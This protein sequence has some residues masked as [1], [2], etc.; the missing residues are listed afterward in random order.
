MGEAKAYLDSNM[1]LALLKEE[2]D[3]R[4]ALVPDS[5]KRLSK[6]GVEVV[7]SSGAGLLAG[8]S[9]SEYEAAGA[10]VVDPNDL[11]QDA[12]VVVGINRVVDMDSRLRGDGRENG[13]PV[14]ISMMDPL[15]DPG[16]LERL[17]SAGIK[18]FALEKIPR[19]SRA[20][21][22]DVLSSQANLAGYKA[23]I[24][25]ADR[26]SKILPMLMT[27]AG[28]ISPAKVLVLGAGV[29]GLQAIATARRLGA[30]V[31]GYDV[32]EVVKEQIE[33]LG[34]KF[35]TLKLEESGEGAGGY[36]KALGEDS[37]RMQQDALGDVAKD[38]DIIISTA[39]I[40]GRPAPRLL[41]SDAIQK[42]KPGSVI[43]DMAAC[44]GGNIE[45]SKVDEEINLHGVKILGPSNLPSQLP[46]DASNVFS[47]NIE[48]FVGL[49][50]KDGEVHI[51][52]G[53]EILKESFVGT[54]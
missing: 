29:A 2:N 30:I 28:T 17:N 9:D 37:Q 15:G 50:L 52:W 16:Y 10:K 23:V 49:M 25:A 24:L 54:R 20:Q 22:M 1:K 35:V 27:A 48:A 40:P 38:M 39:Q 42:M 8:F 36:A 32:R 26:L 31:F 43:V 6:R 19:I 46:L 34:A 5:V 18:G 47:K 44:S 12:E 3:A 21:S 11:L 13:S 41:R 4:V 45:G 33:S 53:D 14:Y 7:V 51:D